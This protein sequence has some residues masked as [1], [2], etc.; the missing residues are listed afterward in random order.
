MVKPLG[1]ASADAP[2]LGLDLV[3]LPVACGE[4]DPP[5]FWGAGVGWAL[6]RLRAGARRSGRRDHRCRARRQKGFRVARGTASIERFEQLAPEARQGMFDQ[7]HASGVVRVA[8]S[9]WREFGARVTIVVATRDRPFARIATCASHLF[10][11]AGAQI[12]PGEPLGDRGERCALRDLAAPALGP[13]W[14]LRWSRRPRTA[15]REGPRARRRCHRRV[16]ARGVRATRHHGD[17]ERDGVL[18]RAPAQGPRGDE[19][20]PRARAGAVRRA[21]GGQRHQHARL[22]G[23]PR[24]GGAV[25]DRA[26]AARRRLRRRAARRRHAPRRGTCRTSTARW[27][28]EAAASSR[29]SRRSGARG[30]TTVWGSRASSRWRSTRS[31][32][33]S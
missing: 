2:A 24:G 16:C 30:S 22:P 14:S 18:E 31:S 25:P 7:L 17:A 5:S 27:S 19:L 28:L 32:A 6:A 29:R 11:N 9:I 21:S 15:D 1:L 3:V 20:R 10:S 13:S 12:V 8:V 23:A 4:G 33:G 26:R